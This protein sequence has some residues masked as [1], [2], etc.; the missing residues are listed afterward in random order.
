M[1]QGEE[2]RQRGRRTDD[3]QRRRGGREGDLSPIVDR[4]SGKEGAQGAPI[5]FSSIL[6]AAKLNLWRKPMTHP[7]GTGRRRRSP[8]P[9]QPDSC[10]T[11]QQQSVV[12]KPTY[13][14]QLVVEAAGVT[15]WFSAAVPSPERRLSGLAISA[16]GALA[17][18]GALRGGRKPDM[19]NF[20]L[21]P[22]KHQ[23]Q[24][25]SAPVINGHLVRTHQSSLW[26]DQ[27]PVLAIHLVVESAGIAEVVPVA[28]TPPQWG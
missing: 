23:V 19:N 21:Q 2:R 22:R 1:S 24:K 7:A 25:A 4:E 5:E 3:G 11:V 20:P 10:Q 6:P 18:G 15:N 16:H 26:L 13:T 9:P 17:S 12:A 28:I 14:V 27:R 8:T